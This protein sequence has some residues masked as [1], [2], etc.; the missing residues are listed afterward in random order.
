M[1]ESL[2]TNPGT[3]LPATVEASAFWPDRER[4]AEVSGALRRE[5]QRT[6]RQ[7]RHILGA[8]AGGMKVTAKKR[9]G[10]I[11]RLAPP[12]DLSWSSTSRNRLSKC[13]PGAQI[14]APP[15]ER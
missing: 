3:T 10:M 14:E 11:R 13:V 2:A 4:A 8:L 6:R 9:Y 15:P 7:L 1:T 12:E 5:Q